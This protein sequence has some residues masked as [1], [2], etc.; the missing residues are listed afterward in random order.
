MVGQGHLTQLIKDERSRRHIG[1]RDGCWTLVG[2]WSVVFKPFIV[3][4][5]TTKDLPS[6]NDQ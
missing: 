4:Y 6:L 1:L 2:W 5:F 3:L